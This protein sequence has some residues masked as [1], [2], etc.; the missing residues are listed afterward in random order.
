MTEQLDLP[1]RAGSRPRTSTEIPHSQLDQQPGDSRH[2]D[3]ILAE[4][5]TW[6]AVQEQPSRISVEG[7]R[8]LVLDAGLAAGPTEAYL[9][10]REFCHVHAHGDFSLH[11]TVP[12]PLA[13]AAEQAGWAEPHFLVRT[14]QAPATVVM[15]YA[16]RDDH[17]RDVVLRLVRAS[18]EFALA[19][20]SH[21][22]VGA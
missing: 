16:P 3:A 15:I 2:V 12:L 19:P 22:A 17:E 20:S 11:A 13:A 7:A 10:G 1:R 14:G 5:R 4:A 21:Q 6:P 9:L 8:A 18:Y